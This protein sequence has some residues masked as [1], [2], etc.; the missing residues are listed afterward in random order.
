[1][2]NATLARVGEENEGIIPID[3]KIYLDVTNFAT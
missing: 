1:M 3:A 2:W